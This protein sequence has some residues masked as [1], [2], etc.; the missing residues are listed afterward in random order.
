M[1]ELQEV[2]QALDTQRNIAYEVTMLQSI[3]HGLAVE[4]GWWKDPLT[5]LPVERD[6]LALLMLMVT[7]LA[8]AAEG[9]RKDVMDDKLPHRKMVEVELA[10]CIIRILDYAGHAKLDIGGA[11]AEKL[12]YN[13]TRADH[14]P[15]NRAKDGGKKQ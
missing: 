4:A 13:V 14:K 5:G 15:E 9:V 8:E 10:D 7:E 2:I 12:L 3:C 6:P 11:L 1:G